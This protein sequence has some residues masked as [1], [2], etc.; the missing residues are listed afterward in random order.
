MDLIVSV[1][2]KL[3]GL[4]LKTV[5]LYNVQLETWTVKNDLPFGYANAQSFVLDR[6]R[7][8]TVGGYDDLGLNMGRYVREYD[9]EN[10][11]W[12]V[13][14]EVLFAVNNGVGLVYNLQ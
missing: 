7:F 13:G 11:V 9:L 5:Q 12:I 6:K 14:A 4:G 8:H 10:D 1:G 2:G 3:G